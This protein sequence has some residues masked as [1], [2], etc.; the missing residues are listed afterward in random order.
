MDRHV[1]PFL[2]YRGQ[3][4]DACPELCSWIDPFAKCLRQQGGLMTPRPMSGLRVNRIPPKAVNR[5]G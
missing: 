2:F 4:T 3:V 5:R 1:R